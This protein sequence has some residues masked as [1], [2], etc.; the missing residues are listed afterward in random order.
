MSRDVTILIQA[1]EWRLT[2]DVRLIVVVNEARCDLSE[3]W[4]HHV[5]TVQKTLAVPITIALLVLH[6]LLEVQRVLW[7][8]SLHTLGALLN[9]WMY[10]FGHVQVVT[11]RVRPVVS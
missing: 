6:L 11:A 7:L 5:A 9:I 8:G 3:V 10:V 4:C 2:W 1:T